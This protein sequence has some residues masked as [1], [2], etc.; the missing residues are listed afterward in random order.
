M[1]QENF[2]LGHG[3]I[4]LDFG[5]VHLYLLTGTLVQF[6]TDIIVLIFQGIR[7]HSMLKQKSLILLQLWHQFLM[8]KKLLLS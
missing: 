1:T 3:D 8:L 5:H 6:L 7:I 4:C 2:L